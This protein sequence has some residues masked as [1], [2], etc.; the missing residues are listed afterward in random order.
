[1]G[2]EVGHRLQGGQAPGIWLSASGPQVK[3]IWQLCH[4]L[5]AYDATNVA[6]TEALDSPL[7]SAD[8]RLARAPGLV[9]PVQ[10]VPA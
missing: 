1:M 4:N 6:L 10:L 5:S 9:C 2:G 8:R 3:S 7:L